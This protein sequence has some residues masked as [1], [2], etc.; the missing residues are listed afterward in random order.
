MTTTT[1]SCS[2]AEVKSHQSSGS[3]SVVQAPL[4]VPQTLS[5]GFKTKTTFMTI[6]TCDFH[7]SP[8]ECLHKEAKA[9]VDKTPDLL[10]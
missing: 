4:E 8:W 3:Q 10:V 2:E 1:S 5:E 7:F 9:V 6:L